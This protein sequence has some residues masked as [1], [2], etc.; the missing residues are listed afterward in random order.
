MAREVPEPVLTVGAC[1]WTAITPDGVQPRF[2]VVGPDKEA[3]RS[4]F[5]ASWRR[6]EEIPTRS[7]I[8]RSEILGRAEERPC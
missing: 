7:A 5:A 3:A 1:G 8:G 6:L 2:A 4:A